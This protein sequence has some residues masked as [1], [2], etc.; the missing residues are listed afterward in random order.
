MRQSRKSVLWALGALL[1]GLNVQAEPLTLVFAGDIM[2]DDGPG[3]LI[4]SGGDPLE[5]FAAILKAADYRIGNL[6]CPIAESGQ[7]LDNKIF[8][9]RAR[10]ESVAVLTG[11]F[12]A[13]ALANNHSGD[14]GQQAFTETI[15]HLDRAGIAHFGGG[16]NLA[17]AHQPLWIAKN[18]LKIAVLGYNEFKPRAFEAGAD[19]PGIAWSEDDQVI[20]DI[21]AAQAAGADLI[22]PFMHWGWEKESL[23]GER[24]KKLA[25]KMIDAGAAL[26]V[27]GHPHVTQGAETYQG[28]PIIYSLGNFVFDG[29]DDPAARRGWL[30]RLRLDKSGVL[31][32]DTLAA[33]M[34]DAGTPYPVAG[35][36]TPCGR[37]GESALSE[38]LNP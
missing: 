37:G 12:D 38:C 25:R 13:M 7:P 34:D 1:L 36:F 2:L 10:P 28:K 21:R 35:A 15:A 3:R 9:F 30:L 8:S 31:F 32:W 20:A 6:E 24:Q 27:G 4:A 23:P 29:F 11:R 17:E 19:W 5:P 14:Y 16:R 18:G 33:Q 26:V 22:I